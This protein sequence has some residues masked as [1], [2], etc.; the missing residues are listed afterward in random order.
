MHDCRIF[1]SIYII[2]N[3]KDCNKRLSYCTYIFGTNGVVLTFGSTTSPM[4]NIPPPTLV[5]RQCENIFFTFPD[6]ASCES[7]E[8]F[9]CPNPIIPSRASSEDEANVPDCAAP[10]LWARECPERD[11]KQGKQSKYFYLAL[12]QPRKLNISKKK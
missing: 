5:S 7:T 6:A 3:I 2:T 8:E 4:E 9:A 1:P 10:H 12:Y 11:I